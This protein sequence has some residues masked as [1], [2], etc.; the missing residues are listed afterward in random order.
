MNLI[1]NKIHTGFF[2][3]DDATT[4]MT[5]TMI[6]TTEIFFQLNNN[7]HIFCIEMPPKKID[8]FC[9]CLKKI[10]IVNI[11]L[12]GVIQF[13]PSIVLLLLI[14]FKLKRQCIEKK[15]C[16]HTKEIL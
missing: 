7:H 5:T 13:S 6:I 9:N 11:F 15:T 14:S 10:I 2:A 16:F 12:S 4:T 8:I 1:I 3:A